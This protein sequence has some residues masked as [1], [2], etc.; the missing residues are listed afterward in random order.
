MHTHF[1]ALLAFHAFLSV[2]LMGTLWRLVASHWVVADS[3]LLNKVGKAMAF[4]Y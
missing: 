4:Q 1:S 2:I 3:P